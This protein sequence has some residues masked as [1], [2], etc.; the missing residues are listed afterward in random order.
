MEYPLPGK[1]QI[2]AW[3][4]LHFRQVSHEK[5]SLIRVQGLDSPKSKPLWLAWKGEQMPTLIELVG[6]YL[7]RFTIEHWYRF[8]KQR[9][10]WTLPNF[11]SKQQCGRWSDLMPM[12]T[13]E[14]WLAREVIVDCPLPWQKSEIKLTPRR[15]AQG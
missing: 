6:L 2:Q 3:H 12:M 7:R 14:L 5:L 8:C 9:L 1:L 11:G 15:T 13:W 10:H 4:K